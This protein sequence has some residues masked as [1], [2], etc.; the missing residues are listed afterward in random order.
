M[1]VRWWQVEPF[2]NRKQIRVVLGPEKK[3]RRRSCFISF[4]LRVAP[5]LRGL[6]VW[7]LGRDAIATEKRVFYL[8]DEDCTNRV[9]LEGRDVGGEFG[10]GD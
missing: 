2:K 6:R 7:K 5:I 10:K 8:R 3:R 1:L 4:C 9:C